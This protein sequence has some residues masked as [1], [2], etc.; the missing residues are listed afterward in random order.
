V[1]R[2]QSA[3]TPSQRDALTKVRIAMFAGAPV[4][5]A[6]LQAAQ[7]LFQRAQ[8]RT[9]YGMTEAL[10]LTDVGVAEIAAVGAGD[11]VLVGSP[12]GGVEVQIAPLDV[13]G[14]P[15][16]AS[17]AD[18]GITGEI[19]IR[20]DHMRDRYDALWATTHRATIHQGTDAG[21]H[22][23]GDVGHLDDEGRLW[24]EG[25]LAHVIV[26]DAGP[27]TPV[28]IEQRVQ[29]LHWVDA[30]AAV[31]IGPRGCQQVVVVVTG[32]PGRG[33]LLDVD[34]TMQVRE[35]LR[36]AGL[37]T[38]AAVLRRDELP[39]DIRHQAKVDR[40]TLAAWASKVLAGAV[41][42]PESVG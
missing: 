29:E 5:L 39:V 30:A 40:V 6:S 35:H 4:P 16:L 14:R 36:Q 41:R 22:A 23:T 7:R 19:R 32:A 13:D 12:I 25:R 17:T 37:A 15:L 3:L 21:W 33:V 18:A 9:P 11:G 38:P 1:I 42:H 28:G 2:T 8:V 20:C 10:P 26:T 27:V 34:R 24:V 31:G